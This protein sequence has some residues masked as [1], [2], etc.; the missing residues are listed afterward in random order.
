[1]GG[2][3]VEESSLF[4]FFLQVPFQT[5]LSSTALTYPV[6]MNSW[7]VQNKT[8]VLYTAMTQDLMHVFKLVL[9]VR[10]EQETVLSTVMTRIHVYTLTYHALRET[11]S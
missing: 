9:C 11:A 4:T 8:T 10:V 5:E 7:S 6:D 2:Y 1:M 3:N